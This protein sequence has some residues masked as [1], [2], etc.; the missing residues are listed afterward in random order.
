MYWHGGCLY[1]NTNP[2]TMTTSSNK[3]IKA[4][5]AAILLTI[6]TVSAGFAQ[7][8]PSKSRIAVVSNE[9]KTNIW[10]SDFPKQTSIVVMDSENNLLSMITTNQYG[11]AFISLPEGI[12]TE[13]IVKTLNGEVSVSKKAVA[14]K[15]KEE[16]NVVS[17]EKDNSPKA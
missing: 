3:M 13:V 16:E 11:A 8:T 4:F 6:V 2:I 14:Q 10:V 17:I 1:T 9:N 12:N 7:T 15:I 5:T